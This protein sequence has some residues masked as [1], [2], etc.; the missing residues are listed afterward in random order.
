MSQVWG[1]RFKDLRGGFRDLGQ[2]SQDRALVSKRPGFPCT[3]FTGSRSMGPTVPMGP[4]GPMGHIGRT[5]LM[6]PHGSRSSL[7]GSGPLFQEIRS[8][9]QVWGPRF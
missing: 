9:S 2:S 3:L 1:P 5:G 6:G 7:P 4:M 8:V